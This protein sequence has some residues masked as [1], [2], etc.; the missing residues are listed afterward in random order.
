MFLGFIDQSKVDKSME[1]WMNHLKDNVDWKHWCFAHYHA[2][3]AE[4]PYVEMFLHEIENIEDIEARWESYTE[5][6][7]LPWFFPKSP[8]FYWY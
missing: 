8:Q 4:R 3:R 6:G 1:I 2:D 7:E 5:T